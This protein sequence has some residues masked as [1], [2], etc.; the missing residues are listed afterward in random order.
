MEKGDDPYK[1]LGVEYEATDDE[2]KKAYRKGALKYHP[3]KQ[4]N[5]EDREKAN[6][7]FAKLSAA[8][9][10]LTDPVKRYDWK[11]ANE[12]NMKRSNNSSD[13]KSKTTSTSSSSAASRPAPPRR[14]HTDPSPRPPTRRNSV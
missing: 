2:I 10:V 14:Q 4:T 13:T 6:D 3:D 1:I 7:I 11:Q 8:Y 12:E 5:D 9:D